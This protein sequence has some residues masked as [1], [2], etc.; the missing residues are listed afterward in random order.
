MEDWFQQKISNP[1]KINN[2]LSQSHTITR[3]CNILRFLT[4]VK[5]VNFR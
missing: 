3:L 4:A 1:R 5:M 2:L